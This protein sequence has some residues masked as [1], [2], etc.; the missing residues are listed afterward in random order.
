MTR[1]HLP[2]LREVTH[3]GLR[4]ENLAVPLHGRNAPLPNESSEICYLALGATAEAI[5]RHLDHQRN[6][7]LWERHWICDPESP[8][9]VK[10][11]AYA[12]RSVAKSAI[13]AYAEFGVAAVEVTKEDLPFLV[14]DFY[15]IVL[16]EDGDPILLSVALR[17]GLVREWLRRQRHDEIVHYLKNP[18]SA[19]DACWLLNARDVLF[20]RKVGVGFD[21]LTWSVRVTEWDILPCKAVHPDGN[22]IYFEGEWK[23]MP[24]ADFWRCYGNLQMTPHSDLPKFWRFELLRANR[25]A[26]KAAVAFADDEQD[27]AA[28]IYDD[29]AGAV[30]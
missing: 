20:G 4:A 6:N 17:L 28:F 19:R 23:F 22:A 3:T 11:V 16:A 29:G 13:A 7:S 12:Y 15:E 9:A 30:T 26:K 24:L 25:P 5:S 21:E 10:I 18:P 1:K 27:L 2:S 8:D 14:E